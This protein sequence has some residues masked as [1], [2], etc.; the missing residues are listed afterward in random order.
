MYGVARPATEADLRTAIAFATEQGLR[1]SLSG[2]RHSMGGQ[3][4]DPGAL[5][6]DLRGFDRIAGGKA[7]DP[8]A[9]W[10]TDLLADIG[11]A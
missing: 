11:Q 4:A 2:T 6:V 3:A 9:P 5:V 7:F 1:V 8:A 10:F